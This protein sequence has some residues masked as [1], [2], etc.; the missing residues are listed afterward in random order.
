M[1]KSTYSLILSDG[2][3]EAIDR[4]AHT[5]KT[6]RSSLIN[7][8]LAKHVSYITPEQRMQDIFKR[9]QSALPSQEGYSFPA[10]QSPAFLD[11]RAVMKY[12]Y[13]PTIRYC[14][15]LYKG[16][17]PLGRL[18]VSLRSQSEQLLTDMARFFQLWERLEQTYLRTNYPQGVPCVCGSCTYTR[19][20]YLPAEEDQYAD[21]TDEELGKAI[22]LY[23]TAMDST[24]K[25]YLNHLS[26][27][28]SMWDRAA[29][30]YLQY[31]ID[32]DVVI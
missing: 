13:S 29:K 9:I 26:D 10:M 17:A 19:D 1:K 27:P 8:I 20:F 30:H 21:I 11:V 23:V 32:A 22:A 4:L 31:L 12:K 25:I 2:V 6:S 3:V 18:R 14:L 7:E 5:Q 28:D 24:L 15:E 16:D